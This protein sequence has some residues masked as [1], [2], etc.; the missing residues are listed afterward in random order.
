[1]ALKR[2]RS[3]SESEFNSPEEMLARVAYLLWVASLPAGV[4]LLLAGVIAKNYFLLIGGVAALAACW[5]LRDWL[6]RRERFEPA[7]QV[8]DRVSRLAA[9][10][11]ETCVARLVVLLR[12]WE[13]LEERRGTA[14]FDPWAIQAVRND[15][16]AVIEQDPALVTLFSALRSVV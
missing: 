13:A 4:L 3:R 5:L 2:H 9:Q 16:A 8:L 10:A 7:A 11:E 12:E 1:M 14:G 6:R 15:I